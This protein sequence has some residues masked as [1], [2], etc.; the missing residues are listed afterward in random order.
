MEINPDKNDTNP[1]RYCG[2]YYDKETNNIYLRARYY[3]P[4]TGRFTKIDS[5]WNANNMI[6]GDN[7][8]ELPDM[9]SVLQS[10]NLYVYCINNPVKYRDS[11]GEII[12]DAANVIID[13]FDDHINENYEYNS[14]FKIEGYVYGQS[15]GDVAKMRLGLKTMSFNGCEAIAIYNA[16]ITLGN[17]VELRDIARYCE[18]TGSIAAGWGG[19][20]PSVAALLFKTLGYDVNI[21]FD[22]D[23]FDAAAEEADVS[24]FSFWNSSKLTAGLHTVSLT[25][26]SDGSIDVYNRQNSSTRVRTYASVSEMIEKD[27]IVPILFQTIKKGD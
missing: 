22:S 16:L 6:Y 8:T 13:F 7:K 5:H 26:N 9:L 10:N 25:K 11:S 23:K 15:V 18:Y 19:T 27:G 3:N 21:Y 12:N 4:K 20:D 2:D 17:P 1:W 24:I 14:Q